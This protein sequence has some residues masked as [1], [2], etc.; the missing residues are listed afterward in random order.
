VV[1]N[2][3]AFCPQIIY[4]AKSRSTYNVELKK[5]EETGP[6]NLA[7]AFMVSALAH[8]WQAVVMC[9][10]AND[11]FTS[12]V[13]HHP[14]SN[15]LILCCVGSFALDALITQYPAVSKETAQGQIVPTRLPQT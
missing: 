2:V 7:K 4:A 11:C 13:L 14:R 15:P 3:P 5:V 1:L 8:Q 10:C 9:H 6:F 12:S